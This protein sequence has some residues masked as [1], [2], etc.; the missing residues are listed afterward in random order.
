VILDS[1][2]QWEVFTYYYPDGPNVY[3]L[4]R[5]RPLDRAAVEAELTEIAQ[6]YQRVFVLY[7]GDTEAD[8]NKVIE[9]WLDVHTYKATEQW[10]GAVRFVTYAVP[11]QLSNVP[12]ERVDT[13]FGNLIT[14]DG[15]TL[16]T[17][18]LSPG[19]I[20]QIDLYW[21]TAAKLTDR[22]KVFVHV[23]DG[24]GQI[25]TQTDR[26]PGGGLNP[27]TNWGSNEVLIDRYG[28][29]IPEN[30]PGGRY[31][32]EIGLYDF[33]NVRL[34]MANGQDALMIATMD[35]TNLK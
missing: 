19:D 27:T 33:N 15:F 14:L 23:L 21:H 4:P 34:K 30:A 31:A 9:S 6:M 16:T 18:R 29:V 17:P 10:V 26:E 32:I 24:N 20:L 35:V 22:Y 11:T 1:A 3:P 5:S 8:P 7:W 12:Q 13:R 28:V 25:I 2:N